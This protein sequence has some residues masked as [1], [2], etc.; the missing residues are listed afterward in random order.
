[1]QI[2][3]TEV[4][5]RDRHDIENIF[6]EADIREDNSLANLANVEVLCVSIYTQITAEIIAQM[7][8]LKM[9]ATRSVGFDHI[10]LEACRSR[11]IVVTN[12]PDY[13]SFVIAEHALA[14]ILAGTKQICKSEKITRDYR[15]EQEGMRNLALRGKTIGI[16]G[17]GKIGLELAKIAKFG[18][19]MNVLAYDVYHN[20][21][22]QQEIGFDYVELENLLQNSEVISMHCPYCESTKHLISAEQIG[23]MKNGVIFINTARGGVVDTDALVDGL[24]HGKISFAGLDVLE[25]EKNTMKNHEIM[26]LPNVLITPHMAAYT[27]TSVHNMYAEAISQM[28]VFLAGETPEYLVK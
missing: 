1:M 9:I 6:P 10:D 3:F 22:A 23:Q 12:V 4:E 7:P 5:S 28:Q 21:K 20:E 18:L 11:N 19:Q 8:N 27:D 13:G 26:S 16:I 2:C 17:T 14:L 24:K 25:D 15:F